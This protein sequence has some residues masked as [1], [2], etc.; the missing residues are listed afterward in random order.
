MKSNPG[1]WKY[2]Q[3]YACIYL[4]RFS[5]ISLNILS[6]HWRHALYLV[7]FSSEILS[8]NLWHLLHLV[9]APDMFKFLWT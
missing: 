8:Q 5:L 2:L 1:P 3:V 6:V 4:K 9:K 7:F